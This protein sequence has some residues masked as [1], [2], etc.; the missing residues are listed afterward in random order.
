MSDQHE[1]AKGKIGNE[2][3]DDRRT[4]TIGAFARMTGTTERTLRFYDRKGLLKPSGRN[5]QGH[6]FYQEGDLLRLQQILTMKYLDFSL[7]EIAEHLGDRNRDMTA[8]LNLQR[9]LL[10]Q[11]RDQLDKAIGTL[12]RMRMLLEGAGEIDSS[13]LLFFIHNIQNEE[14]Q[15]R[16]LAERLPA[17][18]VGAIFMEGMPEAERLELE[19]RM[20]AVLVELTGYCRE[21]RSTDDE[22][23]LRSGL[24]LVKLLSEVIGQAMEHLSEEQKN[25]M[26]RAMSEIGN[27]EAELDPA[28]FYS[29]FSKE[30]ELFLAAV[31]EKVGI[32]EE[33]WL[34]G[35]S[36][37]ER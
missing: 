17:P 7:D 10:S 35:V 23:V 31:M 9:E 20:T 1:N 5:A 2:M 29:G 11:K 18:V 13:L 37:D 22:E 16:Y 12:D 30:E 33:D 32:M 36:Q 6:R 24:Q 34:K 15:K 26:E 8:T 25:E 14:A 28:L 3:A 19:R 4:Y 21:G 27:P